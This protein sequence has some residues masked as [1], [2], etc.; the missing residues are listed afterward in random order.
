VKGT[1]FNVRNY[2]EAP[3]VETSLIRGSVELTTNADPSRKILLRPNE[4]ITIETRDT[5]AFV[6]AQAGKTSVPPAKPAL[7]HI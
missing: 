5:S 3:N 7:Y 2:P 1:A 4:K 6:N